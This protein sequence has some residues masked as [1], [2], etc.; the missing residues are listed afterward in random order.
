[1]WGAVSREISSYH[2]CLTIIGQTK[3]LP[4]TNYA[5]SQSNVSKTQI[6]AI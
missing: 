6:H 3:I 2:P 4:R 5:L 1:L